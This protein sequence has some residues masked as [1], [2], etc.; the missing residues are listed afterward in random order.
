MRIFT[1]VISPSLSPQ[2]YILN[3]FQKPQSGLGH[4]C[5]PGKLTIRSRSVSHPSSGSCGRVTLPTP[6]PC[7]AS[8]G[9]GR[10]PCPRLG[11]GLFPA[12]DGPQ[13]ARGCWGESGVPQGGGADGGFRTPALVSRGSQSPWR[14]SRTGGCPWVGGLRLGEHAAPYRA[15]G[16]A[17]PGLH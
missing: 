9:G 14:P 10:A 15:L 16:G 13:G 3:T 8:L 7:G 11:D 12:P 5:Y 1:P 6:R 4:V 2:G 17:G